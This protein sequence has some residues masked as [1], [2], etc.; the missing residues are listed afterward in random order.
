MRQREE[1]DRRASPLEAPH[2]AR[3]PY[4]KPAVRYERVFETSALA[5]G[6]LQTTQGQ[7]AHSKK[8]S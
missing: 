5:C 2:P 6:K 7:C 3:K 4:Q 8:T 1:T